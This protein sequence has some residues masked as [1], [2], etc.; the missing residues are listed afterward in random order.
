[1]KYIRKSQYFMLNVLAAVKKAERNVDIHQS[2]LTSLYA[3]WKIKAQLSE[4]F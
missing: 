1:M 3:R 2:N 4:I